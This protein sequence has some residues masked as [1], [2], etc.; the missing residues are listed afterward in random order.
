MHVISL[1]WILHKLYQAVLYLSPLCCSFTSLFSYFHRDLQKA[2]CEFTSVIGQGAFGPVF[3]ATVSTGET[4]AVKVLD[5]N[6]KQGEQEFQTEVVLH[7]SIF[8]PPFSFQFL[9]LTISNLILVLTSKVLMHVC[10]HVQT[11]LN[12]FSHIMRIMRSLK[13]TFANKYNCVVIFC[14]VFACHI[15][16][17]LP[18]EFWSCLSPGI[19]ENLMK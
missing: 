3:K 10:Q 12:I 5:T 15:Q 17:L 18:H 9:W 2:T 11:L 13:N 4:V 14:F 16:I 1:Q 8:L 6:S 19:F 7:H